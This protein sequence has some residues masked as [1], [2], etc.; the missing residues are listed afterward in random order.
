MVPLKRKTPFDQVETASFYSFLI[1]PRSV[2]I[3]VLRVGPEEYGLPWASDDGG[4]GGSAVVP[5]F[6]KAKLGTQ[7]AIFLSGPLV[8]HLDYNS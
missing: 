4:P 1:C 5:L 2:S 3:D 6:W 7:G 8:P